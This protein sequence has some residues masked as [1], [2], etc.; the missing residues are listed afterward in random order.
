MCLAKRRRL[1]L[2]ASRASD[3][4]NS[5]E[6][7]AHIRAGDNGAQYEGVERRSQQ[8]TIAQ[9]Q[10]F[11][12]SGEKHVTNPPETLPTRCPPLSRRG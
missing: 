12:A 3:R 2:I 9:L 11:G 5:Q 7:V 1:R 8:P 4:L 10:V 6:T